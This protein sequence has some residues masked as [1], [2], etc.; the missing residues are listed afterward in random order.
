MCRT[1]YTENSAAR[2][3]AIGRTI[4]Y[5]RPTPNGR[6]YICIVFISGLVCERWYRVCDF[7]TR[8]NTCL[9]MNKM[10]RSKRRCRG[11]GRCHRKEKT[12]NGATKWKTDLFG[13]TWY[14]GNVFFD[15]NLYNTSRYCEIACCHRTVA[16]R[17]DIPCCARM[18]NGVS[19][20][21]KI[22]ENQCIVF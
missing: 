1:R 12:N 2:M 19:Y 3:T 14:C 22:S 21:R 11:R 18:R 8:W 15:T 10:G 9:S 16:C 13:G 17:L 20:A 6:I 4:A 5:V 7:W